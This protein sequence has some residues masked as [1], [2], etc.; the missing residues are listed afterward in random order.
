MGLGKFI[1]FALVPSAL[2]VA[3]LA[4]SVAPAFADLSG[5]AVYEVEAKEQYCADGTTQCAMPNSP[6]IPS[7]LRF[8]LFEAFRLSPSGGD[9]EKTMNA[10]AALPEALLARCAGPHSI[11][12][13][14]NIHATVMFVQ[15]GP[16]SE[17]LNPG[18]ISGSVSVHHGL[19]TDT[20]S[21]A[22]VALEGMDSLTG[23][24]VVVTGAQTAN[25]VSD[26]LVTGSFTITFTGPQ[27]DQI[28]AGPDAND[29]V[30][31]P[32]TGHSGSMTCSTG[33]PTVSTQGAPPP[34]WESELFDLI[35]PLS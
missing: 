30:P 32:P 4:N 15:I 26:T 24:S 10:S 7:M 2:A 34:Y 5:Q 35:D 12:V 6:P 29:S 19:E 14:R 11:D 21:T 8:A 22:V 33:N 31:P 27:F 17:H 3:G 20:L 18:T 23:D 1:R 16:S 28:V 9:L 25:N 13:H